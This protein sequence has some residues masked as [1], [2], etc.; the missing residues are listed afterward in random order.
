MSGGNVGREVLENIVRPI[1]PSLVRMTIKNMKKSST[2]YISDTTLRDGEQMPG[3]TLLPHEKVEIAKELEEIGV[4]SIDAGFP[5]SHKN[6]IEAIREIVKSV[7][8]P[9]ITALCRA[10]KEDIDAAYEA[11]SEA[12]LHKRGVT[13]FIG[14]SPQHRKNK[15]RKKRQEIIDMSVD[16]IQY[17][18]KYFALISFASEDGS[19]T[20]LDFLSELYKEAIDAGAINIGLTDT[21]GRFDPEEARRYVLELYDR[22]ENIDKALF[23]IHFHN[24]L[25]MAVANSL[26]AIKTGYVDI[27]QGTFLGV[28]ERAGNAALEQIIGALYLSTIDPE[29][30]GKYPKKPEKIKLEKLTDLCN[31]ISEKT[32]FKVPKNQPI[33]GENIFRTEA[34]IHQDGIIKDPSTYELFP[35]ETFGAKREIIVGK[36][37]GIHGIEY[38][39]RERGFDL[40]KEEVRKVFNCVKEYF[41]D[42]KKMSDE[43]FEEIIKSVKNQI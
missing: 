18:S 42:N 36:H 7:K 11:L 19:R 2:L 15:L 24:D 26:A 1:V 31:L 25:G 14:T 16:T 28:G 40:S 33:V 12:P 39:A 8:K 10:K 32:G 20:E 29:I 37:S 30:Y 43:K 22:V 17:A 23:S 9:V 3:G 5:I 4:H 41:N 34:G 38:A 13:I 27:C 35:P 21:I 6:E